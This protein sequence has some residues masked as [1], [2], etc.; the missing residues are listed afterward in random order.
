MN[1]EEFIKA[2]VLS[3]YGTQN[4]ARAYTERQKKDEY[5]DED[6][7]ELY[8]EGKPWAW[9]EADRGLKSAHGINGKTTAMRNGIMGNSGAGQDWVP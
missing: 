1:K 2:A 3:G 7:I 4:A 5:M 8:R 9:C 6:F